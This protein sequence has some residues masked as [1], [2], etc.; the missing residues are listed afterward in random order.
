MDLRGDIAS[1]VVVAETFLTGFAWSESVGW[2]NFGPGPSDGIQYSNTSQFDFGVNRDAATGA[3]SGYAWGEAIGWIAFDTS[4]AGGSQVFTNPD[5]GQFT[6][7]AWSESIGWLSF[8][9]VPAEH[10]ATTRVFISEVEDFTAL[11]GSDGEVEFGWT[12]LRESAVSSYQVY[13]LPGES[14]I[15]EPGSE[16]N[17]QV[18]EAVGNAP[19]FYNQTAVERL[20]LGETRRYILGARSPSTFEKFFVP[21]FVTRDFP[22]GDRFEVR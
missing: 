19:Q 1:G 21:I 5:S 17:P 18:V 22:P 2:I 15:P 10:A 11:V 3:L 14:N 6:G 12:A 9:D 16:V 13:L 20:G 4:A 7:Y 8:S